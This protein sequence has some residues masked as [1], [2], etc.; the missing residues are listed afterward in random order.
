VGYSIRNHSCQP[1]FKADTLVNPI[2]LSLRP[3]RELVYSLGQAQ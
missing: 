2:P 3:T 1:P